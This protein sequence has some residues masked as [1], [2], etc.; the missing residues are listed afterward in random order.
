MVFVV[1]KPHHPS[2]IRTCEERWFAVDVEVVILELEVDAL[3]N[4]TLVPD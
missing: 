3:R 4:G 1:R 2:R